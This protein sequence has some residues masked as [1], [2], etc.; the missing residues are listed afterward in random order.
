METITST[1]QYESY[2][3]FGALTILTATKA[4]TGGKLLLIENVAP[5]GV[6][7]PLHVHHNEDEW[8]YVLEGEITVWCDGKTVVAGPGDHVF[9]PRGVPHTF[10][11][12]SDEAR[13]LL[14]T[15]PADFEGFVRALAEP[16]ETLQ[17]GEAG[18]PD[19]DKIMAAAAAYNI[20]ILGPPGI[21]A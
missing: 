16:V 18:P 6:G 1:Q 15:Q 4:S 8:F 11:V 21:P 17:T 20:E 3:F 7:S 2:A 19:M 5:R 12:T 13:F 14:A 9:G 10:V